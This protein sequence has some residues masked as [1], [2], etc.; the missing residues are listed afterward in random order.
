MIFFLEK[1]FKFLFVCGSLD[2]NSQFKDYLQFFGGRFDDEY[3]ARGFS[4]SFNPL[5]LENCIRKF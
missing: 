4:I 3:F 5:N 2:G 1:V